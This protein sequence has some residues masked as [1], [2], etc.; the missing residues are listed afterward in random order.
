MEEIEKSAP[1]VEEAVEAALADLGISE[2]EA[3]IE[4]IQEPRGGLLGI[5]TQEAV[6]R[7]RPASAG[8]APEEGDVDDQAEIA[9]EF[10]EG[11]LEEM[12]LDAEIEINDADEAT[13]VEIWGGDDPEALGT[14]IGRRGATLEA[15]QDLVRSA[16]QTKT[17][18]RCLVLV[19]VEDYRKRRRSQVEEQATEA[20]GRV[21]KSG[22]PETLPPMSSYERKLV[23]DVAASL[24]GL[25]T[26][27]EGEEP[28][29][30]V[31][32]RR[33]GSPEG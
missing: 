3:H 33:S 11:L 30:S 14:L 9:A 7:V 5:G 20:G 21:K 28:A 2:Q 12:G 19:D 6:V 16:V 13:Y 17:G 24:G 15:L 10:L 25:E 1:S 18:Q 8:S 29:R 4:V 23:H 31:V 27:S 22:R 26:A 32:I